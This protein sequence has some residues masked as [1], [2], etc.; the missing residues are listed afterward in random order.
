MPIYRRIGGYTHYTLKI[1]TCMN[2][3]KKPGGLITADERRLKVAGKV[4]LKKVA[5]IFFS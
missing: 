4:A 1:K 2:Q 5:R 3:T